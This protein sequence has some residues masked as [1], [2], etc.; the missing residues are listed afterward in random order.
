MLAYLAAVG[1][2]AEQLMQEL[3]SNDNRQAQAA[4]LIQPR[5]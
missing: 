4:E 5:P 2:V 3:G 1:Q